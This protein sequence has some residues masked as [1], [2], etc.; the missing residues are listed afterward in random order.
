MSRT[1][2]NKD[3]DIIDKTIDND[4]DDKTGQLA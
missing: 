1:F 3:R 2:N 4:H